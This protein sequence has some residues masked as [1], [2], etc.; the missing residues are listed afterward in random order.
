MLYIIET[1]EYSASYIKIMTIFIAQS[2]LLNDNNGRKIKVYYIMIAEHYETVER[3]QSKLL[4]LGYGVQG[5]S[6]PKELLILNWF[7]TL[8]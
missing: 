4:K 3:V 5:N 6:K 7:Q 8:L 1:I 2:E